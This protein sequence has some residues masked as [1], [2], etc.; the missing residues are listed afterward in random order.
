MP[1][2]LRVVK[3]SAWLK[4][5]KICAL[6][7]LRDAD[8]GIGH[9]EAQL[10]VLVERL[11]AHHDLAGLGELDGIARQIDEHLPQPHRIAAHGGRH[12]GLDLAAQ[13]EAL[14]AR[15][16]HQN[17]DRL[18]DDLAQPE[19]DVLELE[20]ARLDLGEVQDVVDD[21]RADPRRSA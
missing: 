6:R 9:L 21:L 15:A 16:Q 20:L 19:L 3:E 17:F 4:A 8:A 12:R 14:G 18:L 13:F 5:L 11:D 10:P 7:L 2:Y 1:P